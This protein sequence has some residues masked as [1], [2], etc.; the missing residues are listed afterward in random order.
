M[1]PELNAI[2][3]GYAEHK[4]KCSWVG[5]WSDAQEHLTKGCAFARRQCDLC[6]DTF[7]GSAFAAHKAECHQ[8]CPH[9][10]TRFAKC[11]AQVHQNGCRMAPRPC[12]WCPQWMTSEEMEIHKKDCDFRPVVCP[13]CSDQRQHTLPRNQLSK[14]LL[15]IA[16]SGDAKSSNSKGGGETAEGRLATAHHRLLEFEDAAATT[17]ILMCPNKHVMRA[18]VGGLLLEDEGCP[19]GWRDKLALS[20][21]IWVW[22]IK[23]GVERDPAWRP[24]TIQGLDPP[25]ILPPKAPAERKATTALVA[26]ATAGANR[27]LVHY[28]G[29]ET[30]FDEWIGR[31]SK[32]L[33]WFS[34][35]DWLGFE[36]VGKETGQSDGPIM[37]EMKA[38]SANLQKASFIRERWI[39]AGRCKMPIQSRERNF[40]CATCR[41]CICFG[42]LWAPDS[43]NQL[44]PSCPPPPAK[45]ASSGG[46]PRGISFTMAGSGDED[47]NPLLGLLGRLAGQMPADALATMLQSMSAE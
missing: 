15:A 21:L 24:A 41:Y 10:K 19:E 29:Y 8:T 32:R 27:I 16:K 7:A 12:G 45:R 4:M 33:F 40:A 28:C 2:V 39:C 43:A 22:D 1:L 44:R 37:R 23:P 9:C 3:A 6:K 35:E 14:H 36:E 38:S 34:R 31:H 5:P 46:S 18:S 25:A 26:A 17:P 30:K 13:L 42:C 47:S 20:Q 11:N